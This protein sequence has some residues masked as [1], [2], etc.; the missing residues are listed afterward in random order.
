MFGCHL[1][2]NATEGHTLMKRTYLLFLT[3]LWFVASY[4]NAATAQQMLDQ[5]AAKMSGAKS[6]SV[7]LRI[8]VNIPFMNAPE[9]N[10]KLWFKAPNKTHIESEGFSMIPKQGADLS[11]ARI[12]QNPYTCVD[13]GK[14]AFQG[15]VMRKV[16]VL[17]A[18]D[19]LGIAVATI[20]IDTTLMVPR[21]VIT[22]TTKQGTATAEL[23][24]EHASARQYCL[25]SYI[26][27]MMDVGSF[28]L[29]TTMTGD[30]DAPKNDPKKGKN[31]MAIVQVWYSN[32]RLNITIPDSTFQ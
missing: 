17:P 6:Y 27:L 21:K 28:D 9:S 8:N 7:Q 19:A 29:P 26:K 2:C 5:I 24:Y 23:V 14:E 4:A 11:A 25:P 30:F 10:A 31:S 1:Y 32:Y 3:A 18:D 16:K 15:V 20:Y 12:L 13:A 22:T